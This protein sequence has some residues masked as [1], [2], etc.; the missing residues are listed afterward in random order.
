MSF[1]LVFFGPTHKKEIINL[2]YGSQE[3]KIHFLFCKLL[4]MTAL[5]RGQI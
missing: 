2:K 4:V 1:Q 3:K 5:V